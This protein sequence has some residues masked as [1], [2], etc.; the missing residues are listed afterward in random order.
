[1]SDALTIK[2]PIIDR[3]IA[4]KVFAVLRLKDT[5]RIEEIANVIVEAGINVI[6]VTLNSQNAYQAMQRVSRNCAPCLLGAG[7]VL[8]YD[9][10]VQALENGAKFLVSPVT[11]LDMLAVGNEVGITTMAGALTPTE[12]WQAFGAGADF[13]KLFPLA[14]LGPEYLRAIRAPLEFIRF[15]PTNGVTLDNVNE[16]FSA[17]AAAVGIGSALITDQDVEKGDWSVIGDRAKRIIE[18]VKK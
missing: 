8:G 17:G 3:I 14:G 7:T 2:Q 6:E 13:V 9:S 18:R 5:S 4:E 1:M 16:W 15:V 10:T 12:A 11:D